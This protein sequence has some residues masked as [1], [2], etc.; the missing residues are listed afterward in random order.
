MQVLTSAE[1][2]CKILS[3]S[4]PLGDMDL[5]CADEVKEGEVKDS[6]ALDPF[7]DV[8]I[9]LQEVKEYFEL[10][11]KDLTDMRNLLAMEMVNSDKN[12]DYLMKIDGL[13]WRLKRLYIVAR[14]CLKFSLVDCQV[15]Q[16]IQG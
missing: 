13:Q 7:L 3:K 15:L 1:V 12:H 2:L 4:R 5:E 6:H 14:K 11:M 8:K 9:A 16:W 10:A